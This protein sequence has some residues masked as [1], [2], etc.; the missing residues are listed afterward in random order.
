MTKMRT[1]TLEFASE[2]N[3]INLLENFIDEICDE[4]RINNTYFGNI[5]ISLVETVKNAII[6]G[7][8]KD[9]N[10]KVTIKFEPNPKYLS[11]FVKDEGNGF[12]YKDAYNP[13]DNIYRNN[14][15]FGKGLY[16]IKT[17]TDKVRFNKRGSQI[18]LIF[19]ISS[20]NL[21]IT[22][23]RITKVGTYFKNNTFPRFNLN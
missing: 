3:N 12:D 4:Y 6:Y 22:A 13:E 5:L 23:N 15:V 17:L 19:Y 1:K 10:K 11:F 2:I 21:E 14:T 20:V 7:N 9:P 8:K 18:E 16:L